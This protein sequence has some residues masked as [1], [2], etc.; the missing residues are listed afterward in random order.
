MLFEVKRQGMIYKNLTGEY[1]FRFFLLEVR[2]YL[3]GNFRRYHSM[4][5]L[6]GAHVNQPSSYASVAQLVEQLICNQLVGGSSP[7]TGSSVGFFLVRRTQIR[8][9]CA[10]VGEPG[11]TVNLVSQT[12]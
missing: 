7:S 4:C 5:W 10:G 3:F 1:D 12:E 2:N 8:R 6:S 11:Q 9:G